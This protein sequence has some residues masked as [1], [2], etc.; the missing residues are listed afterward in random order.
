MV[1]ATS[2][3]NLG[4]SC[5]IPIKVNPNKPASS[6]RPYAAQD[7]CGMATILLVDDDPLQAYVRRSILERRSMD[8]E[9]AADAAAAFILVEQPLFVE[10]LG[11]VIVGLHLPGVGG[12]AFVAEMTSRLPSIPVLVLGRGGEKATDYAGENVRFMARP[13]ATEEML[14]ISRQMLNRNSAGVA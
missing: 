10:K 6:S 1:L 11:L 14:T 12:P 4:A 3:G 8:V 7:S 9:R 5:A 2:A 13:V